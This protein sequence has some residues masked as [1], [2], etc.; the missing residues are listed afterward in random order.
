MKRLEGNRMVNRS[1]HKEVSSC[2]L[3]KV[4]EKYILAQQVWKVHALPRRQ[5]RER[6]RGCFISLV[7]NSDSTARLR[8]VW[9]NRVGMLERCD[10]FCKVVACSEGWGLASHE[11]G[12]SELLTRRKTTR[13]RR[14]FRF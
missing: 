13:L 9:L 6:R 1:R 4:F 3:P 5:S 10:W 2:I 11:L 7:R 14:D 8:K 12:T